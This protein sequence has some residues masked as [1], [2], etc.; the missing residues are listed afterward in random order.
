MLKNNYFEFNSK[1]SQNFN[2]FQG[3]LL[4]LNLHH[5]ID[6]FETSFLKMQQLQPLVWFIYIDIFFMW[7]HGED[8]LKLF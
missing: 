1:I 5:H 3:K 4:E 6:N 7:T 8:N 2:K